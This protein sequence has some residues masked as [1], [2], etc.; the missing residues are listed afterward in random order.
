M[1]S[2]DIQV[3]LFHK[4]SLI[5]AVC[6]GNCWRRLIDYSWA[7]LAIIIPYFIDWWHVM[8]TPYK[9]TMSEYWMPFIPT[10]RYSDAVFK[11]SLLSWNIDF[12]SFCARKKAACHVALQIAAPVSSQIKLSASLAVLVNTLFYAKCIYELIYHV[13]RR[14]RVLRIM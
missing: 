11:S 1:S 5:T 12:S 14:W 8:L 7:P 10:A 6:K 9:K 4:L 3:N 13:Q 2:W